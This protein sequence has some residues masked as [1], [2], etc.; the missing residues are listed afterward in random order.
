MRKLKLLFTLCLLVAGIGSL[1]A[2]SWDPMTR[3]TS[4]EAGKKYLLFNA[5]SN[6]YGFHFCNEGATVGFT[7]Q[8]PMAFSS[9]ELDK[10]YLWE[11]EIVDAAQHQYRL[12]SVSSN[13]YVN[14]TGQCSA[15]QQTV[16]IE[17]Y[18][19]SSKKESSGTAILEKNEGSTKGFASITAD[20]HCFIIRGAS[21]TV[22]ANVKDTWNNSGSAFS[23]WEK[24]H[25]IVFYEVDE[26]KL[27]F[28]NDP[29]V[30]SLLNQVKH[31]QEEWIGKIP[32]TDKLITNASQLSANSQQNDEGSLANL[33][34]GNTATYFHSGWNQGPAEFNYLQ[35]E[36]T[37]APGDF[38]FYYAKE[39]RNN[40]CRPSRIVVSGSA[41]GQEGSFTDLAT[42]T[43]APPQDLSIDDDVKYYISQ[44]ISGGTTNKYFRFTVTH[45]NTT[46][47]HNGYP[48]FTLGEFNLVKIPSEESTLKRTLDFVNAV[49]TMDA[50]TNVEALVEDLAQVELDYDLLTAVFRPTTR[51]TS[52]EAGK[53]YMIFHACNDQGKGFIYNQG[54][55]KLDERFPGMSDAMFAGDKYLWEIASVEGGYTIKSAST[56]TYAQIGA[57]L[58]ANATT[59]TLTPF[60][61]LF[62]AGKTGGATVYLGNNE[63]KAY[64]DITAAD[65]YWGISNADLTTFWNGNP[66]DFTTWSN[67]HPYAFYEIVEDV[68][69]AYYVLLEKYNEYA[70]DYPM[71]TCVG[72][73]GTGDDLKA[74]HNALDAA[75][76]TLDN[77]ESTDLG[78]AATTDCETAYKALAAAL[79]N[80]VPERI[81]LETGK[82]Y[83][84]VNA[85]TGVNAGLAMYSNGNDL[86]WN[87][88]VN[89]VSNAFYWTL[90]ASDNK[91]LVKNGNGTYMGVTNGNFI[92]TDAANAVPAA[93]TEHKPGY[94]NIEL[95]DLAMLHANHHSDAG[96]SES[97]IIGWG[98]GDSPY[99][100]SAWYL[101]PIED[102]DAEAYT[103]AIGPEALA[104]AQVSH[105]NGDKAVDGGY[106][107]F[108]KNT[109]PAYTDFSVTLAGVEPTVS[110]AVW[111]DAT[112][113]TIRVIGADD[114]EA[115][116]DLIAKA[117]AKQTELDNTTVKFGRPGGNY[118][119]SLKEEIQ[120]TINAAKAVTNATDIPALD[121]AMD[122]AMAKLATGTDEIVEIEAGK[123]YMFITGYTDKNENKAMYSDNRSDLSWNTKQPAQNNYYFMLEATD[124]GYKLRN[125]D[126]TYVHWNGA[127]GHATGDAVL[128]MSGSEDAG[129]AVFTNISGSTQWNITFT[130]GT[131]NSDHLH[132]NGWAG[133]SG[134]IVCWDTDGTG[135]ASAWILEPAELEYDIYNLNVTGG[136]GN[137]QLRYNN[138]E[139]NETGNG[140]FLRVPAGTVPTVEQ[141]SALISSSLDVDV[142]ITATITP[143]SNG[144][145]GTI[146]ATV[147]QAFAPTAEGYYLIRDLG[148]QKYPYGSSETIYDGK[149]V[150]FTQDDHD[151]RSYFKISGN[152]TDGYTIRFATDPTQHV[153][154]TSTGTGI[155]VAI[156]PVEGEAG[157]ECLW[158]IVEKD[159]VGTGGWNIIPKG[160]ANG[161]NIHMEY[162]N[163]LVGLWSGNNEANNVWEITRHNEATF[164]SDYKQ[165]VEDKLHTQQ[166]NCLTNLF[167]QKLISSA[168]QLSTNA[169]H[170]E[171]N[172]TNVD[173]N[174]LS[175]LLDR[176]RETYFHSAYTNG[177]TEKHY[178]Q[179]ALTNPVSEFCFYFYRRIPNNNLNRP[180][181]IVVSGAKDV[182][183]QPGEWTELTTI[184]NSITPNELPTADTHELYLSD[185]I[186]YST[187]GGN[188]N[189]TYQHLRFTVNATNNNAVESGREGYPFFTMSEFEIFA[190]PSALP[191][192]REALG[193]VYPELLE[194]IRTATTPKELVYIEQRL[195]DALALQTTTI[196]PQQSASSLNENGVYMIFNV[197]HS[198][199]DGDL[200]GIIKNNSADAAGSIIEWESAEPAEFTGSDIAYLWRVKK[201]E[202][203]TY[204]LIP[205]NTNL[206]ATATSNALTSEATSVKIVKYVDCPSKCDDQYVSAYLEDGTTVPCSGITAEHNIWA[207]YNTDGTRGWNGDRNGFKT[208]G[209]FE[210]FAFYEV[211]SYNAYQRMTH[212]KIQQ[213]LEKHGQV[214]YC[215]KVEDEDAELQAIMDDMAHYASLRASDPLLADGS[216]ESLIERYSQKIDQ[217]RQMPEDGKAYAFVNKHPIIGKNYLVQEGTNAL[218]MTLYTENIPESAVFIC[219]VLKG[220]NTDG[221]DR[222]MFVN[223][224]GNYLIWKG[225][226]AGEEGNRGFKT[227]Y[228]ATHTSLHLRPM[229]HTEGYTDADANFF[230]L[231]A[232]GGKRNSKDVP[233]VVESDNT[234]D[235]TSDWYMYYNKDYSTAFE[236]IDAPDP[237]TTTKV[238]SPLEGGFF[239]GTYSAEFPTIVPADVEAY[240]VTS[241]DEDSNVAM[242]TL[243]AS[244]G[245]AIP[246]N[247]GVLLATKKAGKTLST[248]EMKPATTESCSGGEEV[249]TGNM[250]VGTGAEAPTLDVSIDAYI[251]VTDKDDGIAKFFELSPVNR[252]LV[253]YRAYLKIGEEAGSRR[254]L[255]IIFG[256]FETG[257]DNLDGTEGGNGSNTIIYDLS[258]RRV[259]KPVK[260]GLYIKDGEKYIHQ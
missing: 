112:T 248:V 58:S 198:N 36:L 68:N 145:P 195:R 53:K 117:E 259:N 247:T 128:T 89:N 194:A 240:A 118:P 131:K 85:K 237:R 103:V 159:E 110:H 154:W 20:D 24:G 147:S 214:G 38:V 164:I 12:K 142:T 234:F 253:P 255:R 222:Y 184:S 87:A 18:A 21:T 185:K 192:Y 84:F 252:T 212:E 41:T 51:A 14:N 251:L 132:M 172:P 167:T 181:E 221:T 243:L 113:K 25:P 242:T 249:I 143:A 233:F 246:A 107:V 93:F 66:H 218:D 169:D 100:T 1:H 173:G 207:I 127:E 241:K 223:K 111:V 73:Y 32:A 230:G 9:G 135:T 15:E 78:T 5:H 161:W 182:N 202:E 48:F 165:A 220:A 26:A 179:V 2:Q 203:G 116:A 254:P 94:W 104:E 238:A 17:D 114:E 56:G 170:N 187:D 99:T 71:G 43:C 72:Q 232:I 157:N 244:E 59:V 63:T 27:D 186:A 81:A 91:Y 86:R 260:G 6:R 149:Y 82:V 34:D 11:V 106:F 119:I 96:Y 175:S 61:D 75:K 155:N 235:Q 183:G 42:I 79:T 31:N 245:E 62:D 211:G 95:A 102:F 29:T 28:F 52:F 123:V 217:H 171:I 13:Q 23:A 239:V 70:H 224:Q 69:P 158:N 122:A 144:T 136:F 166:S 76:E 115:I 197:S 67:G 40:N 22:D 138:E 160:G 152:P 163:D 139:G 108:E 140:G 47:S 98:A 141:L 148:H 39:N 125:G 50:E 216:A 162:D 209:A 83:M 208:D 228:D 30:T 97:E 77:Y 205:Y 4:L 16:Y 258:G 204:Q 231:M 210:P 60:Q 130:D 153:Y 46:N 121:A 180:T 33:I 229:V 90:E 236:I 35:V 250:L 74:V 190:I 7:Q 199:S 151:H 65:G 55:L 193:H 19:G 213:I 3:A 191:A 227:S 206:Y 120:A 177:P 176:N 178:L 105:T 10:K 226:S 92:S 219:R 57:S 150:M 188:T 200:R 174:G 44:T 168:D 133:D 257:I 8:R 126:G 256:G 80:F 101:T 137:I 124:G 215:Q 49:R 196:F 134:D 189:E 201:I 88:T 146:D 64:K 37:E 109:T 225:T 129:T 156:K 54:G 45:I